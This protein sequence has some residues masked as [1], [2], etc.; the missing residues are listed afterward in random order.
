M[1]FMPAFF[2][3]GWWHSTAWRHR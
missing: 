2:V 3:I 1:F